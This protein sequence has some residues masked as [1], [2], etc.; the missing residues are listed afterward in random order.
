[1]NP[2]PFWAHN[3]ALHMSMKEIATLKWSSSSQSSKKLKGNVLKACDVGLHLTGGGRAPVYVNTDDVE[4]IVLLETRDEARRIIEQQKTLLLQ[5]P[6][7][8]V[9]ES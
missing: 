4:K 6:F 7:P 1:M 9:A 3:G 5:V 2:P 8:H